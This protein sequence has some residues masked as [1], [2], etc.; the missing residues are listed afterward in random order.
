MNKRIYSKVKINALDSEGNPFVQIERTHYLRDAT[1]NVLAIYKNNEL[2]EL[3]IYGSARLGALKGK[4]NKKKNRVLGKKQYDLVNH[5]GN[6]LV[7]ISDNKEGN[8]ATNSYQN[9]VISAQD[10]LAYGAIM[11]GRN[12]TSAPR[13]T[14][15]GKETDPTTG[16]QDY[17]FRDYQT[18]YKRFDRVDPLASEYPWNSTYCFAENDVIRSIDLDGLEK[19]FVFTIGKDTHYMG[20]EMERQ[21]PDVVQHIPIDM[22]SNSVEEIILSYLENCKEDVVFVMI[23]SHG[24][25]D[26]LFGI[27]GN[28]NNGGRLKLVN[29]VNKAFNQELPFTKESL[30][31]ISGCNAGTENTFYQSSIAESM[32]NLLKIPVIAARRTTNK[33]EACQVSQALPNLGYKLGN[34]GTT[35]FFL[36]KNK[37]K[38]SL[39]D[40]PIYPVDLLNNALSEYNFRKTKEQFF[41]PKPLNT[42][43][44]KQ[45]YQTEQNVR[46]ENQKVYSS[47]SS[48]IKKRK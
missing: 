46:I 16:W 3:N 10:Y 36:F 41:K 8:A 25:T 47:N 15:N 17:G 43:E 39:G 48:K 38:I 7:S 45:D 19:A 31:F 23:N 1:G 29:I 9:R 35:D 22:N 18:V 32:A 14:F 6:V 11:Q 30:C 4:E 2:E 42:Y 33:V 21:F 24:S 20:T 28:D 37:E 13:H 27:D 34:T 44:I 12:T 40:D 5:L 26:R